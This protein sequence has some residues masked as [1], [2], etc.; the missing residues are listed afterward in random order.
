MCCIA[1][2]W[3]LW[4]SRVEY[5]YLEHVVCFQ[6]NCHCKIGVWLADLRAVRLLKHRIIG[7]F[8]LE[9]TLKTI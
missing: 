6:L 5:E 4:K 9:D 8:V 2:V 1:V 3:S 7:R